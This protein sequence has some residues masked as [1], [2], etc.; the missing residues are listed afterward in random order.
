MLAV[1]IYWS[2]RS[3]S[4]FLDK[5]S[6]IQTFLISTNCDLEIKCGLQLCT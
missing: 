4:L 3:V 5:F 2:E 6:M 1:K